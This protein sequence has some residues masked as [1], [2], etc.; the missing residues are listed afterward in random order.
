[1]YSNTLLVKPEAAAES[2]AP[3]ATA[4]SRRPSV[5]TI[6]RTIDRSDRSVRS[7]RYDFRF[8]GNVG[9]LEIC[10]VSKFQFCTT[11]GGRKNAEKPKHFFLIFCKVRFGRFD[12]LFDSIDNVPMGDGGRPWQIR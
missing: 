10:L 12:N 9:E 4:A 2:K 11:L 8:F 7:I 6:D 5:G 1:M 3:A